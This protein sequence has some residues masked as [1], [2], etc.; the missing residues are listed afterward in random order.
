MTVLQ[1]RA[2]RASSASFYGHVTYSTH[3]M[4]KYGNL[5]MMMM[6]MMMMMIFNTGVS[7]SDPARQTLMISDHRQQHS[8][9]VVAVLQ[10]ASR[11]LYTDSCIVT[12]Y[13]IVLHCNTSA[14]KAPA[15]QQT[16]NGAADNRRMKGDENT[17][18]NNCCA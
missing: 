5:M 7:A 8:D 16:M 6:M 18:R 2:A 1:F 12:M 14:P 3:A 4:A 17:I 10:T 15:Q 11:P 13:Y 9:Y